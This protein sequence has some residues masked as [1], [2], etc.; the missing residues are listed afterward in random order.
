MRDGLTEAGSLTSIPR[1]KEEGPKRVLDSRLLCER[2]IITFMAH[3]PSLSKAARSHIHENDRNPPASQQMVLLSFE[4]FENT[5]TFKIASTHT[6]SHENDVTKSE[7][8]GGVW[9]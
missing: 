6:A 5:P 2:I 8:C 1:E 4:V 3:M 7:C 9:T